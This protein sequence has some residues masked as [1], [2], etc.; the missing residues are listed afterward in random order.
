M[1]LSTETAGIRLLSD[2]N[3][4]DGAAMTFDRV[5]QLIQN[6]A[7]SIVIHMFVWRNDEIG[8]QI[9]R[10]I[11][12]AADRGVTIHIKKDVGAFMYERI[13]MN[14]K[15][16]FN[17]T[18]SPVKRLIY[19][20][21][22]LTFPDTYVKDDY[23]DSLG[24][25]VM[26]HQNVTMEWVNHTHSKYYI[27]DRQ[28]MV[29]GS[30]NIEDRHRGYRD[31]MVEISGEELIERFQLRNRDAAAFDDTRSLD[32]VFNNVIDGRKSFEI[33]P[34]MLELIAA[35]R[36]SLYIEM[37]YIGDPD[38]SREIIE[39]AK[40]GV[41]VTTLFSRAANIGNDINYRSLLRICRQAE[42][43]VFLSEKMIHSKLMLIDDDTVILGS[44]NTSIFSMQKAVEMD[45]V[46]K[47]NPQFIDSI[48]QTIDLRVSQ[49]SKVQ[50]LK[51]LGNY[52]KLVASLQQLHQLLH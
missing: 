24:R 2:L 23:D 38:I 27:F 46:V 37:A 26:A 35:A 41:E 5:I 31:Y 1:D 45:V 39:A 13:E 16:F 11:L 49:G 28:I 44:A 18:I 52:N 8:N 9:G 22:A 29:T 30:I 32:F 3:N 4:S 10:E 25:Q 21:N 19:K 40:R 50:S 20:I 51:E 15:S 47:D 7:E 33:K 12:A 14:R 43:A 48:K 17:V 42:I 6:A 34:A 36:R